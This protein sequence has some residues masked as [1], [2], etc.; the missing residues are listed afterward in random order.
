M[1]LEHVPQRTRIRFKAYLE[2]PLSK[3]LHHIDTIQLI[4]LTN[5]E[6]ILNEKPE[7]IEYLK[8]G[9]INAEAKNR[10]KGIMAFADIN[11]AVNR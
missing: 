4:C 3:N 10:L 1:T 8:N 2:I 7:V 9:A 5:L 6:N 11:S